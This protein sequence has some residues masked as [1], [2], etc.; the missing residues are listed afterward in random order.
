M[1]RKTKAQSMKEGFDRWTSN[2]EGIK[3]I[4]PANK[5]KETKNGKK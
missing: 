3:V 2:G 5:K 4:K 1:A